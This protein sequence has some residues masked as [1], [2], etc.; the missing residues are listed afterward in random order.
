M[1]LLLKLKS[2]ISKI[3]VSNK[4]PVSKGGNKI[5][6]K[7]FESEEELNIHFIGSKKPI[8]TIGQGT[9]INGLDLY[10]WDN[11][12][13]IDIGCYCSIADKITILAGG[14]H[15]TDWV[16]TYPFIPRWKIKNLYS[17]Q[18]PRYKGN[19]IIGNDV[20]I[21][22]NVVILSGVTIGDGAVIGAGSIIAKDIPPYC[23]VV[24]NP[25]QVIKKRF[26]DDVIE[27]LLKI[28]WW[29]WD[30]NVIAERLPLFCDISGF[31]KK[32]EK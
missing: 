24:G 27:K 20:W 5:S 17:K 10:C 1:D 21:S 31:V 19:I 16:S 3:F 22:N 23:I 12:I 29:N 26:H 9:Y 14:E 32:Y 15:D 30:K 13:K 28:A 8:L 11:R 25:A 6:E 7:Q 4:L 18:E 2:C